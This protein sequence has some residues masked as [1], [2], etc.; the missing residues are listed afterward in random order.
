[1]A[2][3]RQQGVLSDLFA[4]ALMVR[5]PGSVAV[6]GVAGGNGLERL[7]RRLTRRIV[8]IDI[9]PEYLEAVRNRFADLE[10][11]ELHCVDLT[12][13]KLAAKPVDL[14]HTALLLE[15]I[16]ADANAL[17]RSLDNAIALIAPEGALSVVLQ[18]PGSKEEEVGSSG[19]AS[20]QRLKERF[21]L[22]A[23]KRLLELLRA[24]GLEPVWETQR[25]QPNGKGFWLGIF[26]RP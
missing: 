13:A 16:A 14:V 24:R 26:L 22:I 19:G 5:R 20:I 23:P 25:Q 4:E 15:H 8:G 1:M 10:G 21:T 12:R 6:L 18:L 17:D 7:E 2:A 11:L 9:Q 3:V